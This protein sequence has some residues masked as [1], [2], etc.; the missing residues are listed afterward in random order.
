MV[1]EVLGKSV[2]DF[3]KDN[4]F[5]PFPLDQIRQFTHQILTSVECNNFFINCLFLIFVYSLPISQCFLSKKYQVLHSLNLIHTDLK[6]ENIL[7]VNSDFE[8]FFFRVIFFF[9]FF[10]IP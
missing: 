6:P 8:V 4:S 9:F 10:L 1:F 2:F 5:D 7:L 3:L